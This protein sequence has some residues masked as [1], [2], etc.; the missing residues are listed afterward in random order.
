MSKA[1]PTPGGTGQQWCG[2]LPYCAACILEY[3]REF[4]QS[5]AYLEILGPPLDLELE[6]DDEELSDE[7]DVIDAIHEDDEEK[8]N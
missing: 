6:E 7:A 4:L 5:A 8:P 1:C 3:H 2:L